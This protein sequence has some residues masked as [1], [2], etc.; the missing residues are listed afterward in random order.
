[1]LQPIMA[2][3]EGN[4]FPDVVVRDVHNDPDMRVSVVIP[5]YNRA[6]SV[7]DA[8]GSV[9]GQRDVELE[10][11]V[12]DDGSTDDTPARLAAITDPRL[13]YVRG[14][15]EGVSAA[16]NLGV[17]HAGGELVAFLDSDDLWQRDKLAREAGYLAAHPDVDVVFSDLEKRHGDR[18]FASF[19]RETAVFSRRL[20]ETAYPDGLVLEPRDMQLC[21]L[22]EVPVKPSALVV[23][24]A[25]F[26]RAGGFDETWTSSE[27]WEFLLRLAREHRFAY[28]DRPLAVLF[29]SPDSLHLID[30]SRGEEA[31]IRLLSRERER[32]AGDREALAAARRGLVRRIK[33]CAWHHLDHGRR[34]RAFRVY[35]R[36]FALTGEV[37]LLARAVAAWVPRALQS[38]PSR[39]DG[40]RNTAYARS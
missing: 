24:R 9:L 26:D 27:D 36:G 38:P 14:R 18:V 30:Q 31:M 12:V 3:G 35:L 5:T 20:R 15:H 25:A 10:L 8:I 29:I 1:M 40:E 13:R 34:G 33:H 16:R 28:L 21:L 11:I 23:R 32:L 4:A 17:K 6:H 7:V 22:E 19:M 37:G 39:R 2:A